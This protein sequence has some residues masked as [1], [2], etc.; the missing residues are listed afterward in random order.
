MGN[1]LSIPT[2]H[3]GLSVSSVAT[4][5]QQDQEQILKLELD[6]Y[7]ND[8]TQNPD[9]DH[10]RVVDTIISCIANRLETLNLNGMSFSTLPNIKL[11]GVGIENIKE[12][13]IRDNPLLRELPDMSACKNL[14][15]LD[16]TGSDNIEKLPDCVVKRMKY[17]KAKKLLSLLEILC[18]L[19]ED[20]TQKNIK[21]YLKKIIEK[22]TND[23][24][25]LEKINCSENSYLIRQCLFPGEVDILTMVSTFITSHADE[26]SIINVSD[27]ENGSLVKSNQKK[28]KFFNIKDLPGTWWR[29]S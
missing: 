2:N 21:S 10:A 1:G 26:E 8:L 24:K 16:L 25:K 29:E 17:L 5:Y 19:N 4:F 3:S 20:S 12:I 27:S 15:S 22:E 14:R 23:L 11:W 6:R 18:P 28:I 9:E 7:Q 13:S